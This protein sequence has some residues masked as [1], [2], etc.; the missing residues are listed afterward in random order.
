MAV[1]TTFTVGGGSPLYS[2][3]WMPASVNAYAAT[4]IYLVVLAALFRCLAAVKSILE[5]RAIDIEFNHRYV[6]LPMKGNSYPGVL[7]ENGLEDDVITV[8]RRTKGMTP[9]PWRI[10]TDGPRALIQLVYA[11]ILYFM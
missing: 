8:R 10:T 5:R 9:A 2:S 3:A 4:C 11:G 7:T 6:I 1:F